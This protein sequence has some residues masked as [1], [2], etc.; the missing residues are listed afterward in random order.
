MNQMKKYLQFPIVVILVLTVWGCEKLDV[1]DLNN[2][3]R[4]SLNNTPQDLENLGEAS[5]YNFWY[6]SR[7]PNVE[8]P[9]ETAADQFTASW[10]NFGWEQASNEPRLA[11]DNTV[12]GDVNNDRVTENFYYGSYGVI[13]QVNTVIKKVVQ[14]KI[15]LSGG[16]HNA[17]IL[18]LCYLIQG[19]SYGNLGLVFDKAFIVTEN[20]KDILNLPAVPYNVIKDTAIK[21]LLKVINI[22]DSSNFT[23][24][25]RIFNSTDVSN[26]YLKQLANT[27]IAKF[28]VLTCRNKASN[29]T[30]NWNSVLQHSLN[31][32]T[33]DFGSYFDGMPGEGGH[34]YD[35]NLYYLVLQGYARIDCRI[36][37]LIDP[38]Y[39]KHY[40]S[41][42]KPP[43]V[44]P[45]LL[46]GQADRMD[47]RLYNFTDS[48][49]DFQF[50]PSVNFKAERGYYHYS[51]YR[52]SRFDS[53]LFYQGT[54]LLYEF[55]QY[56]NDLYQAEAYAMTNQLSNAIAI[57]NDHKKPR[58][59]RGHLSEI[60]LSALKTE[61]LN[62]IFY[63]R[64]IELIAQG[65][66]LGFC[67]MRRRDILQPGTFLHYPIP[68]LELQTLNMDYYTFGGTSN[69][70]GINVSNGGW[71]K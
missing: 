4:A 34:W 31:G 8:L 51:N 22:C 9:S 25:G 65:F 30:V 27:Y 59:A 66:M 56:E 1:Q 58:I 62:A 36:I 26:T 20:T 54:G 37:N 15:K 47:F 7:L 42:G 68:G 44:H 18:A 57:L 67:D 63:E 38:A 21:S 19:I 13:T 46:A 12:A 48:I 43:K 11:W 14:D 29:D 28:E 64:D 32:I 69:E 17:R 60:P 23:L 33:S 71:F 39:P 35:L 16:K 10:Y 5:Y 24:P 55:R 41:N 40:P 3:N 6:N 2:P 70:D 52:Y 49:K 53:L 45:E 50:L 61:V